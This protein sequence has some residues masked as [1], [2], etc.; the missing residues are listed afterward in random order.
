MFVKHQCPPPPTYKEKAWPYHL[1]TWRLIGGIYSS[2]TIYLPS[3]KILGQSV[4]EILYAQGMGDQRDLW[5]T[6]FE[7]SLAKHSGVISCTRCWRLTWPLT[8]TSD[9]LTWP[10]PICQKG[11]PLYSGAQY[12]AFCTSCLDKRFDRKYMATVSSVISLFM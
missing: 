9:L 12:V 7:A 11:G 8:L 6:K 3:S 2:R 5:P 4:L 1:L 10:W